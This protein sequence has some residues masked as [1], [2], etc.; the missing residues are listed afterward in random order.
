MTQTSLPAQSNDLSA[1]EIISLYHV[2][3]P[4]GVVLV[5]TPAGPASRTMA[6][7]VD[8][9]ILAFLFVIGL[10]AFAVT[11]DTG[12]LNNDLGL[13][14]FGLFSFGL[15]WG[16][17][18]FFELIWNGQT[19]GK[20]LVGLRV[21]REGGRPVDV[22]AVITRNLMRAIDFLPLG[23]GIGLLSLFIDRYNRRLGDLAAGTVVAREG[24]PIILDNILKPV[25]VRVPQR[26]PDAPPTPLLPNI[27]RLTP[28]ERTL[29]TDF[30]QRRDSLSAGA[31]AA[32]A[33]QLAVLIHQRLELPLAGGHPER[34]LE[35]VERE[36]RVFQAM[37]ER[38]SG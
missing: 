14:L 21:L 25:E 15:N 23:Y 6:A 8:Y 9:T 31:R 12:L 26:A 18:V 11:G 22:V 10:T 28:A 19:P 13:A 1:R 27:E 3:T 36:Y 37:M 4:E 7:V 20:R 17:Y 38:H 2:E 32:L 5:Y 34:F 24:E 30:L 16:Y 29:I 35:H 33:A